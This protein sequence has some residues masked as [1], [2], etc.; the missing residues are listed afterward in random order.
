[1]ETTQLYLKEDKNNL[2]QKAKQKSVLK[3]LDLEP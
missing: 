3:H 1:M 2:P